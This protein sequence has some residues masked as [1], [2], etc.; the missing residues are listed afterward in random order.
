[1]SNTY[2]RRWV[3]YEIVRSMTKGNLILGVHINKIK[4]KHGK[5]KQLGPNPFN[6]LGYKYSN[7]GTRVS[8][9]EGKNGRWVKYQDY[10]PYKLKTSI[11][12]SKRGKFYKLSSDYD[13]YNWVTDDGFLNFS[14][15][16]G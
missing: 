1:M 7:D 2:A 13:T 8:L 5:T 9:Y 10:E 6:Y 4:D 14:K 16:V 12:Q 11:D 15:W 3:R